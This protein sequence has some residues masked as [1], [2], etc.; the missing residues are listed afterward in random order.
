M[1]LTVVFFDNA[2]WRKRLYPFASTRPVSNLRIGI[3][4]IEEKWAAALNLPFTHQTC[5]PLNQTY[6]FESQLDDSFLVLQANLLPSLE[7]IDEI[8]ALTPGD[9]LVDQGRWL[10]FRTDDQDWSPAHLLTR[11]TTIQTSAL[12]V[13]VDVLEDIFLQNKNQILFDFNQLTKGKKTQNLDSSNRV[14]GEW[15]FVEPGA[16][17]EG[18]TLNSRQGPIYIGKNACIEEGSFLKGFVAIG[19]ESRVKTGARLYPG[20][21]IGP[22]CTVAGEINQSVLWGNSQ[23]GHEGYLGCSV[24]GEGCNIGAGSS[25]SNLKNTWS[26]VKLFD[27]HES[28]FRLTGENKCGL[29]MGDH[30]MCAINSSF[31]TGTVVGVGAQIA[32][33]KFIPKFVPDFS[34]MTDQSL[35]EYEL[36]RFLEMIERKRRLTGN[37]KQENISSIWRYIWEESKLTRANNQH[38]NI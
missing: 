23:K 29:F 5:S 20:T 35:G 22:G 21:S 37:K 17:V 31:T 13:W 1:S 27:Y 34:W 4:T 16:Q 8:S 7:L 36:D 11:F 9:A 25:N 30:A 19:E 14:F 15:V 24:I 32:I 10:A 38:L 3:Q 28:S 26:K 18:A 6:P 12:P 2:H 33:S